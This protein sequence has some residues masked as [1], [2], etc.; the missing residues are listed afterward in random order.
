MEMWY[1]N[2]VF[3]GPDDV[4][5]SNT[6]D[7][8]HPADTNYKE[9]DFYMV[10][11]NMKK[12]LLLLLA[13]CMLLSLI[14]PLAPIAA[15]I[16]NT[17]DL[18]TE[19]ADIERVQGNNV[20]IAV[21]DGVVQLYRGDVLVAESA[22][23]G[24]VKLNGTTVSDFTIVSQQVQSNVQTEFGAAN[25]LVLNLESGSGLKKTVCYDLLTGIDGAIT[26]T[27]VYTAQSD[28]T[29]TD[30][31]E[32]SFRLVDPDSNK[33]WS[34]NGGGEGPQS[35]YDT[36]Q[37]VTNGFYRANKQDETAVGV[38]VSDI[39]SVK[40]G[41]CVGDA[42][43]YHRF[44]TVPV[45]GA[46]NTANVCI[47]WYQ[48]E[49]KANVAT[50]AGTAII[51]VHDGDYYNGLKIYANVMAAQGF[52]APE[53]V[54][55]TSYELRWEGWGWENNWT[56]D[57]FIGKLD[58]LYAQGVRQ[59]VVDDCWYTSAGDW[60]LH[61]DKF[62]NGAADMLRLTDAIHERGMTMVLWWRPMDGGRESGYY[63]V[64]QATASK[65]LA[66]HP[67]YFV[68]NEDGSF[69]KL[70]GPGSG[71]NGGFN[72]STGYALC[73]YSEGAVQSQVDF[74]TRA[75]TEWGVDGFKSDYVWGVPKCYNEAHNHARP[76]E[77]TEDAAEIFYSAIYEAMTE[78]DP[79]VFHLLCNCGTPQDYYSLPYV[80]QIPTA[81]PTS[82]DQTRRRVKAY[83]ALT[84][85]TF[86]V[87]TDH[88]ELWYPSS[89]GTG[90]VMIEKRAFADGSAQAKE[91]EKWLGI[92]AE[93]ELYKG[94]HIGDLYAYGIDPYETYVIE[95][96]GMT[97]YSFYKD[98]KY[99]PSG[100]PA[101]EL[102]G[103]EPD[104]YYRIEDYVN[105]TVIAERVS[106]AEA[107][108]NVSFS[109]Y[110]LL[111]AIPLND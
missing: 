87:T 53:E 17:N 9:G 80:T 28:V 77:S 81:D 7:R 16:T 30:L 89:V 5:R 108:F 8:L 95:K 67:E 20:S 88:N 38:P 72:G 99:K 31:T 74:V 85:D 82:V 55:S 73:P 79:D 96:D 47:N 3:A 93:H 102:K 54:P 101:I 104:R 46:N 62:P 60:E 92:A 83:K 23:L 56:V 27:T 19:A 37:K 36:I 106:G 14:Q 2:H 70:T 86:P 91:Y 22:S 34:Y 6:E 13:L 66:E 26:A 12:P 49:L 40:G 75:I 25:R 76:E 107:S 94:R 41:V 10:S 69:A 58:S 35:Y 103:L 21:K 59:I 71:Q 100:H 57:K 98:G 97:Y 51:G 84:S 50:D 68:K 43:L 24:S 39:Y 32:A 4:G 29:L 44:L 1:D 90:A 63:V 105:G 64:H 33:I 45:T 78:L 11:S 61:P 15:G 52:R 110:L 65:L 48:Q 42:S 18:Q 109:Q 111:R